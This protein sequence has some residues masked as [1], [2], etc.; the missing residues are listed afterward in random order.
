MIKNRRSIRT[1]KN[2]ELPDELIAKLVE[3]ARLAPTAGNVQPFHLVIVKTEKNR[4]QLSEATR[5]QKSLL[6]APV[7]IVVCADEEA[8]ENRYGVRGKKL[9]C[10]QDTAAVTQNILLAAC[11][12]GLG[13]C[14]VGAFDEGAIKKVINA[15]KN[16]RPVA[17]IPIGYPNEV[18]EARSIKPVDEIVHEETF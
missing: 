18:P 6:E 11:A 1:Y 13:T 12:L 8:A 7:V 17:L 15:P 10:L 5:N 3:A 16:I 9:Y 4:Q 14:W 2:Q